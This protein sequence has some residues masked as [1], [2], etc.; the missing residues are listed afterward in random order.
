MIKNIYFWVL[1]E[2]NRR[3]EIRELI[4]TESW[5]LSI[6]FKYF[7]MMKLIKNLDSDIWGENSNMKFLWTW[8]SEQSFIWLPDKKNQS[9]HVN[10][11]SLKHRVWLKLSSW[12]FRYLNL[13]S[14]YSGV[15]LD[16]LFVWISYGVLFPILNAKRWI[17][18]H[19]NSLHDLQL[20][21]MSPKKNLNNVKYLNL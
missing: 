3:I 13:W 1:N 17:S 2:F 8:F 4:K 7:S 19:I 5:K 6:F 12:N 9:S 21:W 20:I 10:L 16:V 15:I 14:W 11:Y 18:A